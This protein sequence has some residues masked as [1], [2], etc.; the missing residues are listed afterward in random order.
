MVD[1]ATVTIENV[2]DISDL[3]QDTKFDS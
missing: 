1:D 2:N 3:G